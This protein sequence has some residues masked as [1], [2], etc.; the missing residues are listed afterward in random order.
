MPNN[1]LSFQGLSGRLKHPAVFL[2]STNTLIEAAV[3][4]P[5]NPN[6]ILPYGQMECSA[7][8]PLQS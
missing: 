3:P 6:S 1:M 5:E 8:N 4:K 2:Q 7:K